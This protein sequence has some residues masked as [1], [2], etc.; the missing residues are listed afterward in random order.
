MLSHHIKFRVWD[1]NTKGWLNGD[2][3]YE[4]NEANVG[5]KLNDIFGVEHFV[6]QM[7]TGLKDNNGKDIY[8][9]GYL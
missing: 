1:K 5:M 2:G 7:F 9:G 4:I 8:E 3:L 6:F